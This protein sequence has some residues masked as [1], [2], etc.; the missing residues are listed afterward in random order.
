MKI[1]TILSLLLLTA[2][3]TDMPA[4]VG[5]MDTAECAT[6]EIR[7]SEGNTAVACRNDGV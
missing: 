5:A 2:C 3:A 7:Q 4:L 1:A 6:W